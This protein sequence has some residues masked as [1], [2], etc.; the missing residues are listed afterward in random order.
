MVLIDLYINGLNGWKLFNDIK[1][2][3]KTLPVIICGLQNSQSITN[4]KK[5]ITTVQ[6]QS[7]S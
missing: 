5:V 6:F 1:E 4:L 2:K 3:Y 7:Q